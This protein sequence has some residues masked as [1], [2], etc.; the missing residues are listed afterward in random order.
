MKRTCAAIIFLFFSVRYYK[1]YICI[2]VWAVTGNYFLEGRGGWV[3]RNCHSYMH[4]TAVV[5]E[6]IFT[7]R[8]PN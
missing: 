3:D 1:L 7:V 2:T 6:A 5:H 4:G 8:V